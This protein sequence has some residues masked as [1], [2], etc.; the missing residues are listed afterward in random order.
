MTVEDLR[1]ALAMFA[2]DTQVVI[3]ERENWRRIE[4]V[5]AH[6]VNLGVT[7]ERV[8]MIESEVPKDAKG[9]KVADD[10]C[11]ECERLQDLIDDAR[12][13]LDR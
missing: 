7:V 11:L 1:S 12:R 5:G 9:A 10:E 6:A 2:P 13:A 4:I 3:G 8:A